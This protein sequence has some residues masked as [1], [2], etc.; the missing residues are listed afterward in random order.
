MVDMFSRAVAPLFS[1]LFPEIPKNHPAAGTMLMNISA[2]M[3][4][5]D[6]A[7]TPFGLKA[8]QELQDIN[9]RKD[10]AIR[11]HDHVFGAERLGTHAHSRHGDG[12][13]RTV[14]G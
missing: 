11:T 1:K 8:M 14:R 2:N 7:A 9:P 12:L 13:P 4:G 5:L 3:L 6:N 10:E